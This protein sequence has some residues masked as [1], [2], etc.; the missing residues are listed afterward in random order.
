MSRLGVTEKESCIETLIRQYNIENLSLLSY[1]VQMCI[2][3]QY[4]LTTIQEAEQK[5]DWPECQYH[6]CKAR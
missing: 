2:L 4:V 6:V 5:M 3:I 1:S